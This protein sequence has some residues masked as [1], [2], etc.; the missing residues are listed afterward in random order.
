[1]PSTSEG[2]SLRTCQAPLQNTQEDWKLGSL[3]CYDAASLSRLQ[4]TLKLDFRQVAK[5][6]LDCCL[7]RPLGHGMEEAL[8][9]ETLR[10][11]PDALAKLIADHT[12]ACSHLL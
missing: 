12:Q 4:T 6:N 9:A 7:S 8:A 5:G 1:L 3:G 10:C 2:D 11:D